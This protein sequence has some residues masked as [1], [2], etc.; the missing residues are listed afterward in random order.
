MGGGSA[1]QG[2]PDDLRIKS[3]EKIWRLVHPSWF[4]NGQLLDAIFLDEV[5]IL[6][7]DL[8]SQT[9][10]DA[11]KSGQ[12]QRFGI[13]EVSADDI[14]NAGCV[15]E[16]TND[17][18][19]GQSIWPPDAHAILRRRNTGGKNLR[20]THQEAVDLIAMARKRLPLLRPPK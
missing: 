6:R 20:I 3:E 16:I 7:K 13:L 15:F 4:Q 1:A 17:V 8:V 5:S 9:V 12:F 10:I 19:N 18:F 14:R 2:A 11:V